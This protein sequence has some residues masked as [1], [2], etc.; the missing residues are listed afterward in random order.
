MIKA[1]KYPPPPPPAS[2]PT[3]TTGDS[4]WLTCG[5]QGWEISHHHHSLQELQGILTDW[6]LRIKAVKSPVTI[7]PCRNYRRFW[8][9]DFWGSRLG[10][11]LSLPHPAGTT[12]D[13]DW[14]T[15]DDQGW[16]IPP[17]PSLPAGTTGILTDW[18]LRIKAVKSPVTIT[19]CRNYRRFWLIDFWGSR[20]GNP[21]SLPHPAG[22]T[23][24]SDWLTSDDQ[25]WEIP[26]PP[27]N[28]AGTIGDSDF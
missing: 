24:D 8:L 3:G 12:G 2:H 4:D 1:G 10:N 14:L 13:S 6:L 19:P 22:T 25:G 21:P 15:S 20:L 18:L 28:P 23:G 16:E 9:I 17:P 11:P 5:H 26:P 27:S 7:T